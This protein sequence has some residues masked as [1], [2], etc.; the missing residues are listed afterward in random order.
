M[1]DLIEIAHVDVAHLS[2][3]VSVNW[4]FLFSIRHCFQV[5]LDILMYIS[6]TSWVAQL[7]DVGL[8]I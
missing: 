4:H 1:R 7:T 8:D 5:D 6:I 3:M 2:G